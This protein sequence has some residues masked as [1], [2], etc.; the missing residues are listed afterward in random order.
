MDEAKK[1]RET[2]LLFAAALNLHKAG[3]VE[4]AEAGC[5]LVLE[6]EPGNGDALGLLGVIAGQR[7][8]DR[9]SVEFLRG[10]VAGRPGNAEHKFNL[11]KALQ[12]AGLRDEA[13]GL[14]REGLALNPSR[15]RAQNNLAVLLFETGRLEEAIGIYR[16]ALAAEPDSPE[17]N[18]NLAVA[19]AHSERLDEAIDILNRILARDPEFTVALSELVTTKQ[20]VCDWAGLDGLWHRVGAAVDKGLAGILPFT[21]LAMPSDPRLQLKCARQYATRKPPQPV[22]AAVREHG[23][24][25]QTR[26]GYISAN[27]RDH[28]QAYYLTRLFPRH[29]RTRFRVF[30][31][32]YCPDDGSAV[33]R[34]IENG[35]DEFR[36]IAALSDAEAAE[37]IR[38]DGID[39]L[40]NLTGHTRNSRIDI[41]AHRPAPVQ[42]GFKGFPATTSFDF[43]DYIIADDLVVRAEDEE[44]FSEKPVY[45]PDSYSP[46]GI[47][48]EVP[49]E[50]PGRTALGLPETGFV[51][52]CFNGTYKITPGVFDIWMGILRDTPGSVLWLL[53]SNG[54]AAANLR[55]E[56]AARE[57]SPERIVMAPLQP[58]AQHLARQRR[59][60][61]F[62]DTL[63]C[64]AHTTACDALFAG[65]PVLTCPGNTFAGRVGSSL[66]H[67]AGL[68]DL[69]AGSPED[70]AALARDLARDHDRMTEIRRRLDENR[71]TM[72]LFDIDRFAGNLEAAFDTMMD[73][74]RAGRAPRPFHV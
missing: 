42:V 49:D 10:A 69:V 21:L 63:P 11:A 5:R 14:Y 1:I 13:I 54:F 57:I 30:G 8:Q 41:L 51:F 48:I 60:D 62:L 65:L 53:E 66:L 22:E 43:I 38:A 34:Q 39:I 73:E 31:Y 55:R 27:F 9:T 67:A 59:A 61:L 72:P 74:Y 64:N 19:L 17:I 52:C 20:A 15:V 18:T 68:S 3:R 56:A 36:D 37:K 45:L 2:L 40:I 26:I 23:A 28:A 16:R 58:L 47:E 44:F 32:A 4:A 6:R 50:T 24:Q 7:G 71:T 35:C 46:F 25:A 33:R 29:D 12:T 70:Y